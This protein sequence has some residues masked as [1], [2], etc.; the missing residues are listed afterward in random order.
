MQD[1]FKKEASVTITVDDIFKYQLKNDNLESKHLIGSI[2]KQLKTQSGS[3][4][5]WLEQCKK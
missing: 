5:F 4:V 1:F 2:R 3:R